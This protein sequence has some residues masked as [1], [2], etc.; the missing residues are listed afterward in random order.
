MAEAAQLPVPTPLTRSWSRFYA[1]RF[2]P[3]LLDCWKDAAA[4]GRM[5]EDSAAAVTLTATSSVLVFF[6]ID[7]PTMA[8]FG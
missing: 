1:S 7:F 3:Y 5:M 8:W 6:M 4:V 2:A